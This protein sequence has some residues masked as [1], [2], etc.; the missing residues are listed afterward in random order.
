MA[1]AVKDI[2]ITEHLARREAVEN[3]LTDLRLEGLFPTIDV[4][5]LLRKFADGDLNEAE[6]L[7]AV[8]PK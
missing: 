3:A 7:V 6:L 1:T 4:Q 5:Q 8:L 2:T